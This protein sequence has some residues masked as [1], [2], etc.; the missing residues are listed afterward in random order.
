MS[1]FQKRRIW[2]ARAAAAEHVVPVPAIQGPEVAAHGAAVAVG[3]VVVVVVDAAGNAPDA[4]V[5]SVATVAAPPEAV[6]V[7]QPRRA[8]SLP[9][10]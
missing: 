4:R 2:N 9:A 7:A 8:V 10:R 1:Q 3:P 6:A 5:D